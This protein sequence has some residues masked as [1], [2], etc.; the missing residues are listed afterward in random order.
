MAEVKERKGRR[1]KYKRK[2][3]S[4]SLL[5]VSISTSS[6][7]QVVKQKVTSLLPWGKK[8]RKRKVGTNVLMLGVLACERPRARQEDPGEGQRWLCVLDRNPQSGILLGDSSNRRNG[9]SEYKEQFWLC[10]E[11]VFLFKK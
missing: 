5:C 11:W 4:T 1:F 7:S 2:Q 10:I 3:M 9:I 8:S 6:G